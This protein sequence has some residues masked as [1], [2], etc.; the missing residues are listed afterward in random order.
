MRAEPPAVAFTH[1]G[2]TRAASSS[3]VKEAAT[4]LRKPSA[5]YEQRWD[6]SLFV[7]SIVPFVIFIS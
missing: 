4:G 1:A 6:L 3:A 7:P 2:G 5:A